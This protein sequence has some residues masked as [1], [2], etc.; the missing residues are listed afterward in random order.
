ML[1]QL[2]QAMLNYKTMKQSNKNSGIKIS[3]DGAPNSDRQLN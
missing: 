1:L 2:F 3:I